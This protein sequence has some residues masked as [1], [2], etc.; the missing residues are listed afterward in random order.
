MAS[1]INP[2]PW[3]ENI[4]VSCS[5]LPRLYSFK[6]SSLVPGKNDIALKCSPLSRPFSGIKISFPSVGLR[7]RLPS[8]YLKV[9]LFLNPTEGMKF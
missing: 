2:L 4:T 6:Y 3:G 7:N 9:D 5:L 1:N 8:L